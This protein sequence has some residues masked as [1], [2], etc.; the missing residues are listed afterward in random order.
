MFDCLP[1]PHSYSGLLACPVL[2]G[3]GSVRSEAR[4][5]ASASRGAP[6]FVPP[7]RLRGAVRWGAAQ[8][9]AAIT[10]HSRRRRNAAQRSARPT[11]HPTPSSLPP[12]SCV[13]LL[14]FSGCG[15]PNISQL[16]AHRCTIYLRWRGTTS[17]LESHATYPMQPWS[18]SRREIPETWNLPQYV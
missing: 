5:A 7:L 17:A 13:P 10:C 3:L 12:R 4:T 18:C 11:P 16:C 8:R 6:P 2:R 9:A 15:G 1:P 14:H